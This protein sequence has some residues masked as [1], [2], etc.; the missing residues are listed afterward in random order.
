MCPVC[1]RRFKEEASLKL[2][3]VQQQHK[4]FNYCCMDCDETFDTYRRLVRHEAKHKKKKE[5]E[6]A[7]DTNCL[8]CTLCPLQFETKEERKKHLHV[9]HKKEMLPY[10]CSICEK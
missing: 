7:L 2:H 10:G 3:M 1:R 9:E 6:S 4:E 8:K 5:E